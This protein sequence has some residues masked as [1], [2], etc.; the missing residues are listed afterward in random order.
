M[1]S[2]KSVREGAQDGK[3][4]IDPAIY[5]LFKRM[6]VEIL[7]E[8]AEAS[9]KKA[10][11]E[12]KAPVTF[13]MNERS[14]VSI[15]NS[16]ASRSSNQ[17]N[18]GSNLGEYRG[19]IGKSCENHGGLLQ[20]SPQQKGKK[21][22]EPKRKDWSK[23][24]EF[25]PLDEPL[26]KVLEYML[27]NGL[28]RLPKPANPSTIMGKYIDQFCRYHQATGH[29]TEHCFILKNIVQDCLDKNLFVKNEEERHPDLLNMQ[30]QSSSQTGINTQWK[31]SKPKKAKHEG[32]GYDRELTPLGQPIEEIL[33]YML[34]RGMIKLP[35]Q[36]DPSVTKGK[37][38]NRFCKFHRARGHDTE[39]CFVL[40]NIVQDYIDKE[41]LVPEEGEEQL[42]VPTEPFPDHAED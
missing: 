35:K 18:Q 17:G 1:D 34:E 29:D 40:K 5:Q 13:P 20:Y 10:P 19:Q 9:G 36:D 7:S 14:N 31:S 32:W 15:G 11:I 39:R 37:W 16:K 4:E 27:S 38:K 21:Q 3:S 22:E 12:G 30:A 41:L 25:T 33:K 28:I 42:A 24:R 23:D 6:M 8:Q 2:Q 26:D